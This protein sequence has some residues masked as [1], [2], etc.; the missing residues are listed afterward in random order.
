MR[1]PPRRRRP[2]PTRRPSDAPAAATERADR[3]LHGAH[4]LVRR[5]PCLRVRR[6]HDRL[7]ALRRWPT[8]LLAEL[9]VPP[10]PRSPLLLGRLRELPDGGGRRPECSGVR[11]AGALRGAGPRAER[12]RVAPARAIGIYEGGLVPVDAGRILYRFRADH[13]VVATGTI[14]QPLLFPGNDL[15]GVVLPEAVRRLVDEWAVKPAER[16]VVIAAD[17]A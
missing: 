3:P 6:R 8:R 10:A 13:V 9:Q 5:K 17:D 14:E 7:R 11:R 1:H 16:A 2:F 15:V 12:E 4:L